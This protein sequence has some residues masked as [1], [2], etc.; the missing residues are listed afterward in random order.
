MRQYHEGQPFNLSAMLPHLKM[1][2]C[3]ISQGKELL[4]PGRLGTQTQE[5]RVRMPL[6]ARGQ[7]V[8][9]T[10]LNVQGEYCTLASN[11]GTCLPHSSYVPCGIA[12]SI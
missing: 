9:T 7:A 4:N 6:T 11:L 1:F 10:D 2:I 5:F 12:L 3:V 8:L